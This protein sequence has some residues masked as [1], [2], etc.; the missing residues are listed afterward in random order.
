MKTNLTILL[1]ASGVLSAQQYTIA[2][3]AGGALPVNISGTSASLGGGRS[4]GTTVALDSADNL[5]LTSPEYHV[6]LRLSAQTGA[7]TLVAGN[8]TAGFSGDNGPATSAQLNGPAGVAVDS[9]G[10]IYIADSFNNRVR[11]VSNGII[12]TV[13]GNGGSGFSGDNGPAISASLTPC[14]LAVDSAGNFY[15]ADC[16]AESVIRKVS[17]G[18]ITTVAGNGTFGFSGDNGPALSAQLYQP[19]GVAVDSGGNIYIADTFNN[20]IRKVSNG[21]ITTIAGNGTGGFAGDNGPATSSELLQPK[22]VAVDSAGNVYLAVTDRVRRVS[23][24][25]ISTVAGGGSRL[26]DGGPAINAELVGS[27][28]PFGIAVDSSGN[29]FIADGNQRIRKVS[30]GVI[31]TVAGGGDTIGDG[32]PAA[33]AQLASPSGV[34]LDSTGTMYIA[35]TNSQRIR[36]VSNGVITTI[37]GNGSYGFNGDDGPATMAQLYFPSG[38]AVD[39]SG[40]LYFIDYNNFRIREVSNG[41]I[42]TVAGGGES[43]AD[44][45]PA[46]SANLTGPLGIAVDSGGN[47]YI[48]DE[49]TN[50]VRKVSNGVITTVAGNGTAGFSGD[51][52]PA[53]SAQLNE[54]T[55]LAVDS[56]RSLFIADSRNSRIRRV[57]AGVIT[58]IAGGGSIFGDGAATAVSL[59]APT[60][61][62]LDLADNVYFADIGTGSNNNVTSVRKLSNGIITTIESSGYQQGVFYPA[63]IAVDSSNNVYV[64]D[65]TNNLVRVLT[66]AASTCTFSLS[67]MSL[68]APADGANLNLTLTT[69]SGCTWTVSDLPDWIGVSGSTSGSDSATITLVVT[70]NSGAP[71]SAQISVA[72]IAVTVNQASN[73][74]LVSAGGVVNDA[75]YTA[76]VAPGSI[77][78]IFGNFLLA[79][80]VSDSSSPLLSSLDGL[81]F[82]FSGAPL[83]PLFY[84]NLGQ[85]NAQ[86]PWEL[87]GQSQTTISTSNGSQTSTPVA[88]NLATY[89]PGIFAING[90]GTGQGAILGANNNVANS[91]NPAVAGT[92]VVQIYCTGLGP[93]SNQPATGAAASSSPLAQ[94]TAQPTVT[95][96]GATAQVQFSGL[97]PG[98]VGLYQVNALV[99]QATTKGNAVPV[100]ISIGGV[101]SDTVTIAVQ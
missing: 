43:S 71:R 1:M 6:V 62:S 50:R 72:G 47:L 23:N 29:L 92:T 48:S 8:G 10:N 61:I 42:T 86:V 38:V 56:A 74:L 70:A 68:Q 97:A 19:T 60:A 3:F 16:D 83:A 34:V 45:V 30:N 26:G 73:L 85:V 35:D 32:G 95:I 12:T 94:T 80:P 79:T 46:T 4:N 51:N 76:P 27:A 89:A 65:S 2:T 69:A 84:A 99:P 66:P 9:A 21:V 81:S 5:F 28:F 91:A 36:K 87:A 17:N 7:L 55:G 88:V 78:A 41:V 18:V 11:K 40:N 14:G 49:S 93:V 39:S 98:Y 82:Q 96:G 101:Q 53:T 57:S 31:T 58:T 20:R 24:G 52:G 37:A 13:A 77:V 67:S 33:R 25:T 15:I 22:G 54:P 75:S 63:G 100:V 64:A 59:G 90:G 44:N